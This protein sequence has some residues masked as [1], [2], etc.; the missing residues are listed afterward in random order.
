MSVTQKDT[1]PCS[2]GGAKERTCYAA[3]CSSSF[4]VLWCGN[5]PCCSPM[6]FTVPCV[7]PSLLRIHTTQCVPVPTSTVEK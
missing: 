2:Q 7:S 6:H 4:H 3:A 5:Y 1:A